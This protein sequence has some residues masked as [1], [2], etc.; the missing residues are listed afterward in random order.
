MVFLSCLGAY[1]TG[2][3]LCNIFLHRIVSRIDGD[4]AKRIRSEMCKDMAKQ[5][6]EALKG[7]VNNAA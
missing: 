3:V 7:D 6:A 1:I 5:I 2:W 4:Y